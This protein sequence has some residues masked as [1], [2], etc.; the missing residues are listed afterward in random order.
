MT[1]LRIAS[2]GVPVES[3][4]I[5]PTHRQILCEKITEFQ[6]LLSERKAQLEQEYKSLQGDNNSKRPGE[7]DVS[8]LVALRSEQQAELD[9]LHTQCQNRLDNI[10]QGF[11]REWSMDPRENRQGLC[12][13][14]FYHTS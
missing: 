12:F 4:T 7:D 3:S 9:T 2:L 10:Y 11:E 14:E 6:R 8:R 1:S 5:G 13:C